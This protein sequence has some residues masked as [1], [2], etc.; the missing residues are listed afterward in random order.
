MSRGSFNSLLVFTSF[1]CLQVPLAG[2]WDLQKGEYALPACAEQWQLVESTDLICLRCGEQDWI[3]TGR[4]FLAKAKKIAAPSASGDVISLMGRG[5]IADSLRSSDGRFFCATDRGLF[6]QQNE[7]DEWTQ[8]DGIH[9]QILSH[10]AASEYHVVG[11][12]FDRGIFAYDLNT[13]QV[14][15]HI[16]EHKSQTRDIAIADHVIYVSRDDGV[17]SL[18]LRVPEEPLVLLH[19]QSLTHMTL[20]EAG[21]LWGLSESHLIKLDLSR[22]LLSTRGYGDVQSLMASSNRI[23]LGSSDGLYLM[24]EDQ[25]RK[26]NDANVTSICSLGDTYFIGT[27]S[28]GVLLYDEALQPIQLSSSLADQRDISVLDITSWEDMVAT[29]TLSGLQFYQMSDGKLKEVFPDWYGNFSPYYFLC[30]KHVGDRFYAGTDRQGL[31]IYDHREERYIHVPKLSS[32]STGRLSIYDM[33]LWQDELYLASNL[34]L[35]K[36]HGDSLSRWSG[37]AALQTEVLAVAVAGDRLV[38]SSDDAVYGID[39]GGQE[40]SLIYQRESGKKQSY[41]R[42]IFTEEEDVYYFYDDHIYRDRLKYL[43]QDITLHLEVIEANL[44]PVEIV[45]DLRLS[46]AKNNV[47]FQFVV[48]QLATDQPISLEYQMVDLDESPRLTQQRSLYYPHLPPGKYEMRARPVDNDGLALGPWM[49]QSVSI[50]AHWYKLWWIQLMGLAA[51][52][53]SILYWSRRRQDARDIKSRLERAEWETRFNHLRSQLSPHFL[54]N[55]LNSLIGLIETDQERSVHFAERLSDFYRLVVEHEK[56]SLISLKRELEM[57]SLYMDLMKER[58]GQAIM[59]SC[60]VQ[61]T[62]WELPP[63]TLQLLFE[64]AIKHNAIRRNDPLHIQIAEDENYIIITNPVR[65]KRNHIESTG[66]GLKNINE[67]VKLTMNREVKV[68]Q[69]AEHFIVSIPK[70]KSQ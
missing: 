52:I 43:H 5:I 4:D 59:W 41:Y 63:L 40:V 12:S 16:F 67:R 29:S 58:Y 9:D 23:L 18:D 28:R 64:N 24:D 32:D 22:R 44:E 37:S 38:V 31:V 61:S 35:L 62:D 55:S 6:M 13:G 51:L 8:V 54:F 57:I 69:S 10:L 50:R 3:F 27:Y 39:E 15:N 36:L 2:Q 17:Y 34:G 7:Q 21:R 66:T 45:E 70:Y 20:D 25:S 26:I 46:E 14:I 33:A 11:S 19:D 30:I 65:Q 42:N 53:F 1:I 49:T 47:S 56:Q 60:N 68:V 48:A